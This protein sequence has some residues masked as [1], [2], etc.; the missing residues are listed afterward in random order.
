MEMVRLIQFLTREVLPTIALPV[1][2]ILAVSIR[3]EPEH[4][5]VYESPLNPA[6]AQKSAYPSASTK[7]GGPPARGSGLGQSAKAAD[8]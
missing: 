1:S 6:S 4:P 3:R 7:I 8:L 2:K 5:I